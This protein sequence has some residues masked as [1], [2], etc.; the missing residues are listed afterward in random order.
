[1]YLG[2]FTKQGHKPLIKYAKQIRYIEFVLT[3]TAPTVDNF[4][5]RGGKKDVILH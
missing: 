2:N 3:I 5:L 1:V 4:K